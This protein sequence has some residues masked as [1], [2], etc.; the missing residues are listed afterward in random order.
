LQSV[1]SIHV[2][3]RDIVKRKSLDD[4]TGVRGDTG[5]KVGTLL[6]DAV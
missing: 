2:L 3:S 1:S 6:S 5:P 4:G